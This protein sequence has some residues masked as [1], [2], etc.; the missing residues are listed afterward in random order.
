ME[1]YSVLQNDGPG[2]VLVWKCMTEDF[3]NHTQLIVAENEEALFM[4]DGII[5]QTFGPGKY[6]LDTQNYPF[7]NGLRRAVAGGRSPF[8]CKVYFVEKAHKLELLWGTDSPIQMRDPEFLFMVSVMS[9]GSYSIRVKDAKKFLL[10]LVGGDV[11]YFTAQHVQYYFR[12]AFVAKIKTRLAQYMIN[13]K[14]TVLDLAPQLETLSETFTPEFA[15]ILDE[16]GVELVNFTISD[17]SIPT[18]DPNYQK[19][20]DAYARRGRMKVYGDDYG[21]LTG[22][23][24]LENMSVGASSAAAAGAGMGMGMG[25]MAGSAMG[26]IA[27]Q[28]FAPLNQSVQEGLSQPSSVPLRGSRYEP[29]GCEAIT[30]NVSCAACGAVNKAGAKFCCDCGRAFPKVCYCPRCGTEM[31]E[32][33]KFCSEC[34]YQRR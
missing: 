9:H 20:N 14:Q 23:M 31:K 17:I 10:K 18:D 26:G 2:D 30:E 22:E 28:V 12:T 27:A 32:A 33:A 11:M 19:I 3:N 25:V 13:C 8:T 29:R 4:K 15:E 21:R 7:I 24:L 34:G 16:Y 5:V 1:F 6:T